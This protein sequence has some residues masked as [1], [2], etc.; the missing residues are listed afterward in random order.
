MA[1]TFEFKEGEESKVDTEKTII[2]TEAVD[3]KEQFSINDLERDIEMCDTEIV[4]LK[5]RKA[6]LEKDMSDAKKA[7]DIS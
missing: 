7:L 5:E 1:K 4:G 6:D 2:A 3:R